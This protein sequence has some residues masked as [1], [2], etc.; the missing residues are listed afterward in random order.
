MRS[1]LVLA[2][3]VALSGPVVASSSASAQ[4]ERV[5]RFFDASG[6]ISVQANVVWGTLRVTGHEG[7]EIR[8][9]VSHTP[10]GG[11]PRAVSNLAE[12]VSVQSTSN[13]YSITGRNPANGAFE[14]IDITLSV[15]ARADV[16]L[17]VSRGGEIVA[18]GIDGVVDVSQR[19]GSV[20]LT[21]L[22]G[23][24]AVNALNGSIEAS[25]RSV[26]PNRSMSFIALNG[27]IDLTLPARLKAN[28]RLRSERNGYITSDFE[29][30]GVDYPYA[31]APRE[32]SA[33]PLHSRQPIEI[34]SS[35]NGGGPMLVATTEN[36]PIRLR[37]GR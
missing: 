12:Y 7:D 35:I 34:Q 21:N 2:L 3:L 18:N 14:S 8:L 30:P 24:A 13:A 20:E 5:L 31:D 11:S 29:L 33:K 22:G 6:P 9:S 15:P 1:R 16:R 27:E 10:E 23:S 25:F 4:T 36:G 37:R 32:G 28:V 19:N 26:T 17:G